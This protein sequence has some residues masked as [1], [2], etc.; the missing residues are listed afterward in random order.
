MLSK[1]SSC[2]NPPRLLTGTAKQFENCLSQFVRVPHQYVL[3]VCTSTAV[4]FAIGLRT[5]S[6]GGWYKY[7]YKLKYQVH[8]LRTDNQCIHKKIIEIMETWE[9]PFYFQFIFPIKLFM[10]SSTSFY[11]VCL[12]LHVEYKRCINRCGCFTTSNFFDDDIPVT[13][14]VMDTI[15]LTVCLYSTCTGM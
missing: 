6:P 5:S 7:L 1:I 11:V 15:V 4:S 2:Q 8:V 9:T 10:C 14:Y 3:T 12:A 13:F